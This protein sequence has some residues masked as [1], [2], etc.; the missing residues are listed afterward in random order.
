MRSSFSTVH[1][2]A[3][4]SLF[5]AANAKKM[6]LV[7]GKV[8]MDRNAP[9]NLCKMQPIAEDTES[10]IEE[11]HGRGRLRYALTPRFAVTSSEEQLYCSDL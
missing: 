11:W 5:V 8:M 2:H 6:C 9:V 10:L 4:E 3:C 1:R 7:A